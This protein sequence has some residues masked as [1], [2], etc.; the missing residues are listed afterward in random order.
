M[1]NS[2]YAIL[3]KQ[4][5]WIAEKLGPIESDWYVFPFSNT[6]KPI[7]PTRPVT[8]IKSAWISVRE[9]AGVECRFHD[10]RHTACTKMAEAGVPEATMK[11]L[12]GHLS[13][14]M[15]ERYSHIRMAAKRAAIEALEPS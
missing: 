3:A 7:D 10:L 9:A 6:V 13:K 4:A 1:G 15:I 5:S 12:M 2:L 14:G 8:T 11:A